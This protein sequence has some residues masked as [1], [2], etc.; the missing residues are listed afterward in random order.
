[1]NAQQAE[2]ERLTALDAKQAAAAEAAKQAAAT[3]LAL[4]ER[5]QAYLR[6]LDQKDRDQREAFARL[7]REVNLCQVFD[8]EWAAQRAR[9][10]NPKKP[11]FPLAGEFQGKPYHA[12]ARKRQNSTTR[13]ISRS[14]LMPVIKTPRTFRRCAVRR[15]RKPSASS[16]PGRPKAIMAAPSAGLRS[17]LPNCAAISSAR[18]RRRAGRA[19]TVRISRRRLA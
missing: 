19:R 11:I 17:R 5:E 16:M 8:Y 15:L 6:A 18:C 13:P 3:N 14:A 10:A 7:Q 9:V 12:R 1:M 4:G 2:Y